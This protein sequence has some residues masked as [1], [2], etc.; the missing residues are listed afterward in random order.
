M[1][2]VGFDEFCRLPVGTVFSYWKPCI[3]AGL[4]RRG[5]VISRDGG[6]QDF[7]EASL[8]ACSYNGDAPAV[9][10]IESRWGMFDY[11]QQFL[12]YEAAEIEVIAE[13]LGVQRED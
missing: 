10:L 9:D 5:E 3:V 7:F 6:P 1:K 12:V 11:D 8:I 2:I 4:Y 13:G